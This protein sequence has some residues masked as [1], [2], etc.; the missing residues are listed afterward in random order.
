M[1][2]PFAAQEV[3]Q[4]FPRGQIPER[5]GK[6]NCRI[7]ELIRQHREFFRFRERSE[8]DWE[9]ALRFT[10]R[11]YAVSCSRNPVEEHTD[12]SIKLVVSAD[13]SRVSERQS[14]AL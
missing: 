7:S 13:G 3:R 14:F 2:A 6:K 11:R 12:F 4:A 9:E 5:N 8:G 1:S 10:A